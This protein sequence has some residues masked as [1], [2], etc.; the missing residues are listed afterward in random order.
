MEERDHAVATGVPR[1]AVQPKQAS[2]APQGSGPFDPC[3][4]KSGACDVAQHLGQ[5][6]TA[7]HKAYPAKFCEGLAGSICHQLSVDRDKG[8]VR[9]AC[10][11]S[12]LAAW[13]HEAG[14]LPDFQR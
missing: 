5:F 8:L 4:R 11:P 1:P 10:L 13:I 14:P 7:E 2:I 12:D 9:K 6:K 3:S